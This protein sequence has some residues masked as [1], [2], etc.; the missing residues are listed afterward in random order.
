[1]TNR[2]V[3]ADQSFVVNW[4]EDA[5]ELTLT[6]FVP[7][8]AGTAIIELQGVTIA[9]DVALHGQV[10]SIT[11]EPVESVDALDRH[12]PIL[13][14]LLGPAMRL[15]ITRIVAAGGDQPRRIQP[16]DLG[17]RRRQ[18]GELKG[19]WAQLALELAQAATPGLL[20]AERDLQVLAA[21][22]TAVSLGLLDDVIDL[23]AQ[24]EL[25]LGRLAELP[26]GAISTLHRRSGGL[27]A[28]DW[29]RAIDLYPDA[30][31]AERVRSL[32]D[33]LP[34]LA[35]DRRGWRDDSDEWLDDSDETDL[36]GALLRPVS[37]VAASPPPTNLD[38]ER[39]RRRPPVE[40]E[41]TESVNLL[42]GGPKM[43][44]RATTG[45]EYVA[46]L[47]TWGQRA[48]GWWL[49]GF[50][51]NDLLPIVIAPFR[52]NSAGDAVARVLVA[53]ADMENLQWDVVDEPDQRRPPREVGCFVRAL[54]MGR[55]AARH[56]RLGNGGAARELW[57]DCSEWHNRA[58]DEMRSKAA[59]ERAN[60]VFDFTAFGFDIRNSRQGS[61]AA[62][63]PLVTDA[64][65]PM[66]SG[67]R[68]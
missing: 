15:E 36:E 30:P 59:H 23:R 2:P 26:F 33:L 18:R 52:S 16:A 57:E 56:E 37:A 38:E 64:L 28:P 41:S 32:L 21:A 12:S 6:G 39:R 60:Q 55:M 54:A 45:D 62:S 35:E 31:W 50:H 27:V 40:V 22:I 10:S 51:R 63:L 53:P 47:P 14:R 43:V 20:P 8:P 1:M 68:K 25:A 42:V 34:Q 4:S 65:L 5:A 49:R 19:R 11:V 58:G 9:F 3:I 48:T 29:I 46:T 66:V 13:D 67:A 7:G 24:C 44:L 17:G 61:R